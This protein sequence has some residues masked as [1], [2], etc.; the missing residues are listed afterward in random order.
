MREYIQL[1][2]K[3]L[4]LRKRH[5]HLLIGR[6]FRL[7][8]GGLA[9]LQLLIASILLVIASLDKKRKQRVIFPHRQFPDIAVG[10]NCLQLYCYGQDLYAAMLE[11]IDQAKE[12]IYIES[13][14][15]KDDPAGWDFKVHLA[16][17]AAEG[18]EVYVIFDSFG[19]LVVPREFKVF[20]PRIHVVEYRGFLRP[21]SLL[22]PRRY[23][24]D[25]RKLLIIDGKISFIGGYNIGSLYA[26]S[27][28]DTHLRIAGP[29]AAEIA[30][31][32][33]DFW[34]RFCPKDQCITKH[35]HRTFNPLILLHGNDAMRL[36]FPIRDMYIE[37]IQ[38]AETS[39]KLSNA[40]F[41]PD[42]DL[43]EAL[44]MAAQ[45]GVE[46]SILVPWRSNH[47]L[48][49]WIARSYFTECLEAGI[50]VLG[51]L[52]AMLHAKTCTIDGQWSTIGTAN[53]DRLSSIGNYEIN[54]EIYSDEFA[55]QMEEL[56]RCDTENVI[57]LHLEKWGHRP[58]YV[59]F[60]ERILTP[61]RFIM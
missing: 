13:Y 51:Y 9:A 17:K 19:N 35:Y 34:N 31:S 23:S 61:L 18:I 54:V 49:D 46:V 53:L 12:T 28:R 16:Q 24:L 37:A 8:I 55:Q 50:H 48:A 3:R 21:W 47:V 58:F 60:S 6:A 56:F 15:W 7:A 14:I 33:I 27:W 5:F 11:A 39:I 25:H 43:L 4:N 38:R 20:D 59:K 32:F 45:R 30:Q 57:E 1:Q 22:D 29:F 10:K 42:R 26:S 41:M 2:I 44:K 40:Y 36:T 52:P